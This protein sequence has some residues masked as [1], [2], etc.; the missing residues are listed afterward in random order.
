[1]DV[2]KQ[3]KLEKYQNNPVI[4]NPE[5]KNIKP[6]T[7]SSNKSLE[8]KGNFNKIP[9]HNLFPSVNYHP[10]KENKSLKNSEQNL[11]YRTTR[12]YT[13]LNKEY[14][15]RDYNTIQIHRQDE[16][17]SFEDSFNINS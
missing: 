9:D 10:T 16:S 13:S 3:T 5:N 6:N 17:T 8:I 11:L 15:N 14:S 1:M 7:I 2:S 12:I 4:R